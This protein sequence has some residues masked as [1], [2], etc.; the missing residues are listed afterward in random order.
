[1]QFYSK[2]NV[3]INIVLLMLCLMLVACSG[4]S[5]SGGG[6]SSGGTSYVNFNNSANG[7]TVKDAANNNFA[8][9]SSSRSVIELASG[10]TLSGLTVDTS[11]NVL[12]NGVKIGTVTLQTSTSSTQIAA[13]L[14]TNGSRMTISSTSTT[15]RYSCAY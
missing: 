13:F 12:S 5:S 7:T 4:G 9:D 15:Y 10:A 6:G 1:M 14:C 3:S 2:K 8:V 11:S